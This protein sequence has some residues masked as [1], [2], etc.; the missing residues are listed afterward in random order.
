MR[1][2]LGDRTASA[3][4]SSQEEYEESESE[5][6][7]VMTSSNEAAPPFAPSPLSRHDSSA[8]SDNTG[9][10]D[11]DEAR[12]DG[13][14]ESATAL[15]RGTNDNDVFTPQPNAFSHPPSSHSRSPGQAGGSYFPAAHSSA[16]KANSRSTSFHLRRKDHPPHNA[17][18]QSHKADHDAALKASLSTLLSCAA[19]AR[20]LPKHD[21]PPS[22]TQSTP[23]HDQRL[24]AQPPPPP[25]REVA[26]TRAD[27]NDAETAP[28]RR[29]NRSRSSTRS[30]K[31]SPERRGSKREAARS[32]SKERRAVKRLRCVGVD[33]AISPTLMTWVV[34]AG[35]IVLVGAL[36][37]S[38]G[39]SAGRDQG[40]LETLSANGSG[41]G[42]ARECGR[43][44]RGGM[45]LRRRL[46]SGVGRAVAA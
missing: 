13:A 45:G 17:I 32:T 4:G 20:G 41:D 21:R 27:A 40:R 22:G 28:R 43:Q 2:S 15:D 11:D 35:V 8:P 37:F 24:Q 1:L 5:S 36:S 12:G 46:W 14:D 33:E 23:K 30:A 38:A 25:S 31:T 29:R 42:A 3:E 19:A 7:R 39:Y 9:D 6:D 16:A 18:S 10:E 26:P 34:S 44:A